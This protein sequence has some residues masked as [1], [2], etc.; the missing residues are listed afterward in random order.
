MT[1]THPINPGDGGLD[2]VSF[3]HYGKILHAAGRMQTLI[4]RKTKIKLTRPA[5]AQP[6]PKP[7]TRSRG[8][9][10]RAQTTTLPQLLHQLC[11]MTSSPGSKP[12]LQWH[13]MWRYRRQ[14]YQS[15]WLAQ[16]PSKTAPG[17]L[18]SIPPSRMDETINPHDESKTQLQAIVETAVDGII[19]INE[20]GLIETFNP[21]AEKLFG[22]RAAAVLGKPVSMLMPE[23]F[24]SEHAHYVNRYLETGEK[25]I[26]GIGREVVGRRRNGSTFPMFLS[27][28]EQRGNGSRKFTGIVR[29]ITDRKRTE[30]QVLLV[31]ERV[32]QRLGHDLHD[33]LGQVL[34][35]AALLAKA[36][37]TRCGG[38]NPDMRDELNHL[39][40]IIGEAGRQVRKLSRGLQPLEQVSDYISAIESLRA[41]L[42]AAGTQHLEVHADHLPPEA[43]LIHA[44]NLFRIA[45][46]AT[47]NALRHSGARRISIDSTT[48]GRSVRLVIEDDGRGFTRSGQRGLGLH[49]MDYR[50]RLMGGQLTVHSQAGQG[51]RVVCHVDCGIITGEFGESKT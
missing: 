42:S 15:L 1:Q 39:V 7:R 25:R 10:G 37:E 45:Q 4:A 33:G 6:T 14:D 8:P 43:R 51:T 44:N 38:R 16:Q 48:S 22:Y 2:W 5:T 17:L 47:S 28:G 13:A 31:S 9:G 20:R 19:T 41:Q 3:S 27:V 36:L 12:S 32:Q 40:G 26:I 21:A 30:S 49:I 24:K 23:P 35:G 11:R 29:D 18:V 46:E 34:T 50:A